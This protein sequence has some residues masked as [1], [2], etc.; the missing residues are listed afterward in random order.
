VR[1][2]YIQ[3]A[4]FLRIGARAISSTSL[5]LAD[6][7]PW[8]RR[9]SKPR[10][11]SYAANSVKPLSTN[12]NILIILDSRFFDFLVRKW[13]PTGSRPWHPPYASSGATLR[14]VSSFA[15]ATEG[16]LLAFFHGFTLVA[17]CE[18]G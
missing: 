6:M 5:V 8:E 14:S 18:G 4:L 13:S 17:F 12:C 7:I 2:L 11:V 1:K 10:G 15:K 9:K 16:T 3:I